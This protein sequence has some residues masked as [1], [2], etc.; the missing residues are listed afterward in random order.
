MSNVFVLFNDRT[1]QVLKYMRITN[2]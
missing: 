1:L 2:Y